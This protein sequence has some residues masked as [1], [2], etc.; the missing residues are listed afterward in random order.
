LTRCPWSFYIGEPMNTEKTI[1]ISDPELKGLEHRI[2]E[3]IHT[4]QRLKQ[5]NRLLRQQQS[6]LM[7]ERAKL[8]Q[9]NDMARTQTE[10]MLVRLK[11]LEIEA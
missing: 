2:D 10:N 11:A 1:R 7:T 3:L 6:L 8:K 9:K 4:C 5:E